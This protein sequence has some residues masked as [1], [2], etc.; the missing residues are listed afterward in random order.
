MTPT[1]A[2]LIEKSA[3]ANFLNHIYYNQLPGLKK[4]FRRM[5]EQY[6][7]YNTIHPDYVAGKTKKWGQLD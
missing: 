6:H 3:N 1:N 2:T 5:A 7:N 4:D